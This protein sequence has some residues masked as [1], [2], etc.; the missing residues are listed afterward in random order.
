[1]C[2]RDSLQCGHTFHKECWDRVARTHVER[3]R[4]GDL[5]EAPCAVCRGTGTIVAE[6]RWALAGQPA[7]AA[8]AVMDEQAAIREQNAS[9]QAMRSADE[10]RGLREELSRVT[11]QLEQSTTPVSYTHLTL[12]TNREV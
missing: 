3:L 5:N 10:I 7:D 11:A 9:V 12:P 8:V 4:D 2:I 6:Y 1:M